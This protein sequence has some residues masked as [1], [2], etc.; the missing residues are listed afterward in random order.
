MEAVVYPRKDV[1]KKGSRLATARLR[2]ADEVA[3]GVSKQHGQSLRLDLGRLLEVH[4]IDT[5]KQVLV[6]GRAT[7]VSDAFVSTEQLSAVDD[8]VHVQILKSPG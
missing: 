2:L 4:V 6:A 8:Y 3:W 7:W 5:P 1:E